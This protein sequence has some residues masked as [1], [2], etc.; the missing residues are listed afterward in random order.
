MKHLLAQITI[1]G[2]K[3]TSPLIDDQKNPINTLGDVVNVVMRF[4]IPFAGLILLAVFLSGAYDFL[5]SGGS[6]EK[7][8]SGK[9]KLTAG[10]IGFVLLVTSTI[11]VTLICKI[12]GFC[13]GIF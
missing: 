2:V 4:L 8:K 9:A 11:I 5:L 6:P 3:L 10:V 13:G 7:V 1:N 12:F